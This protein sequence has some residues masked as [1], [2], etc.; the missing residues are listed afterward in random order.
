[1]Q[2]NFRGGYFKALLDLDNLLNGDNLKSIPVKD[3][4]E[5]VRQYVRLLVTDNRL[6]DGVITYGEVNK[7]TRPYLFYG[8]EEI[9]GEKKLKLSLKDSYTDSVGVFHNG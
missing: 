9:K 4:G 2:D 5:F 7:Y 3:R 1:M 8:Y 6:R